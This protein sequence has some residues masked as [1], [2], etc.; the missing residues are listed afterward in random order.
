MNFFEEEDFLDLPSINLNEYLVNI[1]YWNCDPWNCCADN[2]DKFPKIQ[3]NIYVIVKELKLEL[4]LNQLP[5]YAKEAV[6]KSLKQEDIKLG[7]KEIPDYIFLKISKHDEPM[8]G[9]FAQF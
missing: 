8:V 4:I 7:T 6:G 2:I 3:L 9:S 5:D 1:V